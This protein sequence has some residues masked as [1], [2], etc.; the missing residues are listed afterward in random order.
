MQLFMSS[1]LTGHFEVPKTLTF[2]TRLS[3]IVCYSLRKVFIYLIEENTEAVDE[4]PRSRNSK[5]RKISHLQGKKV[6][7]DILHVIAHRAH[8]FHFILVKC[9]LRSGV[10]QT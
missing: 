1:L 10:D 9:V 8:S 4:L 7:C 6:S 3:A 2:K 5:K